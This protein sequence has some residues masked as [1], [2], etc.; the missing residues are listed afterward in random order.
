MRIK[1]AIF[2]SGSGTNA[3]NIIEYFH[4]D[5]SIEVSLV[6]SNKADAYILERA[7][8]HNVPFIFLNKAEIL[9]SD[10]LL[11]V[12]AQYQIDFIVLA[13][14]LLQIPSSLINRYPN[15]IVNI[16]PALL[17]KHGGKGMYGDRV[18]QA[19]VADGDTQSGITIHYVDEHYDSGAVIFQAT[20][21]VLPTDSSSDVA[22]KVHQL[23]YAHFPRIIK[24]VVL[25]N[26]Q[27]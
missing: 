10:V 8:R 6:V 4:K 16:H 20:C 9:E 15:K 25:A 14:F 26:N 11:S 23:E 22:T 2:G 18:H 1:I 3:E 21:E 17:P 5:S 7:K 27:L 13:G 12:L 19:V 24:E